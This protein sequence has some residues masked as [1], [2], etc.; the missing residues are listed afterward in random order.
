VIC[1]LWQRQIAAL[2]AVYL[3]HSSYTQFPISQ[4]RFVAVSATIPNCQD[5][6]DWLNVPPA[7][8]KIYGEVRPRLWRCSETGHSS[9]SLLQMY[10]L[11][12]MRPCKL[13]TV[14]RGYQASKN[15]FLFE[16]RISDFLYGIIAEFSQGK[17]TL[18]FCRQSF[19]PRTYSCSSQLPPALYCLTNLGLPY[20]LRL[21]LGGS[22]LP[23]S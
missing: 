19:L 14:V 18:V 1:A 12:E 13:R 6:A 7:G 21:H 10:H 11:Q 3:T 20:S 22:H 5:L 9:H 16:R 23:T 15:D 4:V 17:P 8:L 2:L